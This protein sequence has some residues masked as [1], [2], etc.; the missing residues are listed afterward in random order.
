M[1][2][3]DVSQNLSQD[4]LGRDHHAPRHALDRT[5]DRAGSIGMV[6]VVA[7]LLVGSVIAF[8]F[9]G[10]SNA[11]TYVLILL[12]TLAVIGVFSLFAFAAGIVHDLNNE[13][14]LILNLLSTGS[15]T[16]GDIETARAATTRCGDLTS[17]LLSYWKA[18]VAPAPLATVDA[19][20]IVR[21]L[22]ASLRLPKTID[23]TLDAPKGM[24]EV[25]ADR[26]AL[27]R[28]LMNLILNAADAMNNEGTIGVLCMGDRILVDDGGP[29]IAKEEQQGRHHHQ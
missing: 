6:L 20:E 27:R 18:G 1:A 14:T 28:I 7:L 24:T 4:A 2:T 26:E 11:Q 10:R 3:Q 17:G 15:V 9:I 12:S 29:G 13:L 8:L 23:L 21:D 19:A 25:K 16:K 22:V 5:G